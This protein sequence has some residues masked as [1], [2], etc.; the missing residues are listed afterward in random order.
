MKFKL[1]KLFNNMFNQLFKLFN[2]FNQLFKLLNSFNP[3]FK[4]NMF[5]NLLLLQ[6]YLEDTP[7]EPLNLLKLH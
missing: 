3:L 2:M 6:D 4:L 5:H 1:N 7:L